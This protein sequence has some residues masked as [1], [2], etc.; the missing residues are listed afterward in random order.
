MKETLLQ[1]EELKIYFNARAN[2]FSK[3]AG[4]E[5]RAVDGVSL[6]I[7]ENEIHGLVGESGSGKS[8]LG[9]AVMGLN[10]ISGGDIIFR[11]KSLLNIS[12]KERKKLRLKI[13]MVFQDPNSSLPP[14]M[15]IGKILSE[16]IRINGL[17]P[18]NQMKDRVAELLH[19]VALPEEFAERY[20][21]QLSGG[22]KQRVAV[23]RAMALNPELIIADEPTSALDVSVQAQILNLLLEL[24]EK[25]G[26]SILFISHNLAV[27]RHISDRIS[28]MCGG[29]IVE[30]GPA[31]QIFR[32]P[33]DLY[34]RRLLASVPRMRVHERDYE[35]AAG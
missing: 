6:S 31:E 4:K 8:T 12:E 30:Q 13:Q 26:L 18:E 5:I 21:H 35:E 20:P 11:G 22:Q 1:T 15:K 14:S 9:R 27:V 29:K 25:Q 28:V 32:N 34:T 23:A 2:L 3:K 16:P 10:H 33:Q 17:L 19:L 24:K 7:G